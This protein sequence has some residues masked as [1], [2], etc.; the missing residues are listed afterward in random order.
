[1]LTL[2]RFGRW[3]ELLAEPR[4]APQH[5]YLNGIWHYV[6]GLAL[7]RAKRLDDA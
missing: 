1:M 2:A 5:V 4:P 7:T 6:R 3:D